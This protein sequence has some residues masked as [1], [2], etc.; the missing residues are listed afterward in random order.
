MS[1][2]AE[3]KPTLESDLAAFK[4]QHPYIDRRDEHVVGNIGDGQ[5]VRSEIRFETFSF[6][7]PETGDVVF[8]VRGIKDAL[9]AGKLKFSM[10]EAE[11]SA[12]W[13]EY[14]R[15]NNGVEAGR[16]ASLTAADLER[17]GIVV[18]WPDEHS[19]VI[20]GNNRLVRRWDDGLKTFRFANVPISK[21][22]VPY[23]CRP[24]EEEKFLDRVDAERGAI[25]LG[26]VRIKTK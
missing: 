3:P 25:R 9:V 13:A 12:D 26:S 1:N 18:L 15:I 24:G 20:D 14:I 4:L 6:S 10:Y 11:L 2:Y 8:D 5:I 22:L 7:A 16:M 19:T 21:D 23:I 17:P